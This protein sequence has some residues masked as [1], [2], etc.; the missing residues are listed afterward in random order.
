[1]WDMIARAYEPIE[2][3]RCINW[4]QECKT[5]Q[6]IVNIAYEIQDQQKFRPGECRY[7]TALWVKRVRLDL[8][9]PAVQ[10]GGDLIAYGECVYRCP[11]QGEFLDPSSA[12]FEQ[13]WAGHSWLALGDLI[14]DISLTVTAM[15]NTCQLTLKQAVEEHFTER[16]EVI[17]VLGSTMEGFQKRD[18]LYVPKGVYSNAAI[19]KHIEV[20][21]LSDKEAGS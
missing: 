9:V 12:E 7:W 10:V 1:M 3:N 20:G 5:L 16:G 18:L 14:G 8:G 4:R 19:E 2:A 21:K 15:D 11:E 17:R 13:H 6:G